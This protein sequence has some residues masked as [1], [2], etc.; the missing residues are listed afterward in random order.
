MLTD[1]CFSQILYPN[2]QAPPTGWALLYEKGGIR[3]GGTSCFQTDPSIDVNYRFALFFVND[4]L[5]LPR[6]WVFVPRP[7][8]C[9]QYT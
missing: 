6:P 1:Y 3:H 8:E 4:N 2:L 5:K 7:G 9:G